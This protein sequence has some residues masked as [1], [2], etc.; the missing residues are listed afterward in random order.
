[1]VGDFAVGKTSVIERFVNNQF[2]DKYLTTVGVK[3]DTKEVSL[4]ER[5]VLVKLVIWDVA[6]AEEFGA[7]EFAYL[8][9]ASGFIFVVDGT[10][11]KTLTSARTLREQIQERYGESPAVLLLNKSDLAG[12]WRIDDAKIEPLRSEFND[13]YRTSAKTG[14]AVELALTTVANLVVTRDLQ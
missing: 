12:M 1:V 11:E 2:S 10:R 8:R 5:G 13:I 9:G 14:D 6:G 7:K 3:I 4:E